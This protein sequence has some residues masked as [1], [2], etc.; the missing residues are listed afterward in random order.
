MK[1]KILN[2]RNEGK[3]YNEIKTIL[4]CSKSTVSYYC[5]DD[6][7]EKT[8]KRV[9]KRREN[10]IIKKLDTFK[11]VDKDKSYYSIPEIKNGK[12]L[13]ESLRKFQKRDNNSDG[14]INKEINKSFTWNDVIK[15][16]GE[17]T[18]CYLSGEKINLY[19]NNYNFDHII[20]SSKGGTNELENLGILHKEVNMMKSNLLIEE[21]FLW[22]SKILEHNGFTVSKNTG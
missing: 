18:K 12:N 15:K 9:S 10:L 13:N 7:K 6:Q 16:F 8:K 2:L 11:Y 14:Y 1:E 20:P 22:C 5:G 21:L 19:E 4:G 17:N 3:T